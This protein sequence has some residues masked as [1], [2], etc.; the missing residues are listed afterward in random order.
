MI[1]FARTKIL[2]LNKI[3]K[4]LNLHQ[5]DS[6]S[7]CEDVKSI[8]LSLPTQLQPHSQIPGLFYAE[9]ILSPESEHKIITFLDQRLEWAQSIAR[10]T[11][12]RGKDFNY[13]TQ[14]LEDAPPME[15][16]FLSI[17]SQLARQDIFGEKVFSDQ[18]IINEYFSKQGIAAHVDSLTQ[19]GPVV[20]SISLGA[21]T[22]FVM[23]SRQATHDEEYVLKVARRSILVLKGP[24]RYDFTHQIPRWEYVL[25]GDKQIP[26]Q[27]SYRRISLTFRTVLKQQNET[28]QD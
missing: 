11:I 4:K 15:P 20:V 7:N 5:T 10:R 14:K 9:E 24:A 23:K 8:P 3:K 16:L 26:K 6:A 2:S 25:D 27:N 21:D 22:N 19:F 17:I 12:H 13:K 1:I 18:L 28:T